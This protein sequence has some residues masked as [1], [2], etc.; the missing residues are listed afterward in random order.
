MGA[1]GCQC[2][3]PSLRRKRVLPGPTSRINLSYQSA[4]WSLRLTCIEMS[5]SVAGAHSHLYFIDQLNFTTKTSS[6][7]CWFAVCYHNHFIYLFLMRRYSNT[8]LITRDSKMSKMDCLLPRS[9]QNN[10][11]THIK[12]LVHKDQID[13]FP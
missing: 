1:S 9:S 10:G 2:A 11:G 5:A 13:V 8:I 12:N 7:T 3:D 4:A 6:V